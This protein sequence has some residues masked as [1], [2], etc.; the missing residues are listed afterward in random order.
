MKKLF[1]KASQEIDLLQTIAANQVLLAK[2]LEAIEKRL[3]KMDK[4]QTQGFGDTLRGLFILYGKAVMARLN[5]MELSEGR[6][7]SVSNNELNE[8]RNSQAAEPNPKFLILPLDK[9]L[10]GDNDTFKKTKKSKLN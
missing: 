9:Q 8:I 6:P 2:K 1:T 10:G 7:I 3:E 5:F 4:K